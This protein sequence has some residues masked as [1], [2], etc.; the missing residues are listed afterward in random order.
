MSRERAHGGG[1]HQRTRTGVSP[2]SN[3]PH[4]SQCPAHPADAP[5]APRSAPRALPAAPRPAGRHQLRRVRHAAVT[6][7][8]PPLHAAPRHSQPAAVSAASAA[9]RARSADSSSPCGVDASDSPTCQHTGT[10]WYKHIC[11]YNIY[12]FTS[13]C[14]KIVVLNV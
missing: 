1:T 2:H 11:I 9:A 4:Q 12:T 5:R 3:T 14:E 8:Y 10:T 6:S 7:R 13:A